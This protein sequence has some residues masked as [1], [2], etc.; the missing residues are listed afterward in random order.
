MDSYLWENSVGLEGMFIPI[1]STSAHSHWLELSHMATLMAKQ[2]GKG[3]PIVCPGR[4]REQF[5]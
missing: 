1:G 2:A 5:W 4:K 3:S